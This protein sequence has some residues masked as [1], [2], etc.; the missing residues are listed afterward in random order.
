MVEMHNCHKMA[1][2]FQTFC[3]IFLL[4]RYFVQNIPVYT[5]TTM[6]TALKYILITL[7]HFKLRT[8]SEQ[9]IY[10][11]HHVELWAYRP[12]VSVHT[13]STDLFWTEKLNEV[14][15]NPTEIKTALSKQYKKNKI[16]ITP[17]LSSYTF[18]T[19]KPC[20][21]TVT[22]LLL[23]LSNSTWFTSRE[24]YFLMRVSLWNLNADIWQT[25]SSDKPQETS[26]FL[27]S[28]F[29]WKEILRACC[30]HSRLSCQ[31]YDFSER[32]PEHPSQT[33]PVS[34]KLRQ[35]VKGQGSPTS[36]GKVITKHQAQYF[37]Y[38]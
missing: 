25:S 3:V 1:S 8:G 6:N 16:R 38:I 20:T 12:Y 33:A 32:A 13:A 27:I 5:N 9:P 14:W 15:K 2:L 37:M 18:Q 10:S 31:E 28:S 7:I 34:G 11:K 36:Q 4:G 17:L 35:Q 26:L 30:E 23:F 29:Q 24:C 22:C 21:I 19:G